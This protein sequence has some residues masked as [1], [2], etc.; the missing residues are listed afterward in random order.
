MKT[1]TRSAKDSDKEKFIWIEQG[2]TPGLSY[3]EDVWDSFTTDAQR[4]D[5]EFSAAFYNGA[6]GG[7]GKLTRLYGSVAWLETLRV[8]PDYQGK[9]LGKAIYNRYIEQMSEMN[10]TAIGM[11]TNIDNVASR[12]LAE[13]YGLTVQARFCEYTL[14]CNS[15]RC[16][17]PIM[18]LGL[19]PPAE[20]RAAASRNS[21]FSDFDTSTLLDN[22]LK[23]AQA[24]NTA[25]LPPFIVL[26][27]TFY[28]V[29][30][31]SELAKI[32]VQNNWLYESI[33]GII[34]MGYRFQ[35]Q[36]ALHI[37]YMEGDLDKLL[38][39]ACTKAAEAGAKSLTAMRLYNDEKNEGFLKSHGFI[40]NPTDY[41]TLWKGLN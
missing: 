24:L 29:Q 10:L 36:K 14:S 15:G 7:I 23:P 27:R 30:G 19:R 4:G 6:L 26:N 11:Y 38:A 12:S 37:A 5:G 3:V 1:Y 16:E 28:P 35:P 41:I 25:N 34:I 20:A 32:L 2:A 31:C 40:K 17:A 13:K 33:Y 22:S 8:H 18:L 9:G 39:L 21:P